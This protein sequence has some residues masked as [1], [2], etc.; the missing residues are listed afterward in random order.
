M[1]DMPHT[2]SSPWYTRLFWAKS[3]P[4]RQRGPDRIHL[5]E[6]H[7]ADVGACLEA[8]LAQP[9][10]RQRLANTAGREE[11]D[12][13]TVGRLCVFAAIHDI[14][15]V[16]I[17]FQAQV[18][19]PG[20]M[21]GNR[22]IRRTGHTVDMVPVLTGDDER[23]YRWFSDALG[24]PDL[25]GWDDEGGDVVRDLL[26]ATL[27]HHGL[28]LNLYSGPARNPQVWRPVG[29]LDPESYVRR[30]GE[31][32]RVW[33]AAA[34]DT[35]APPLPAEPSFQHMFL[36]L[37]TLADW[38][39]SNEHWFPY[40][41][42]P[43][44][45]YINGARDR[46]QSAVAECG[47][48]IE[49]QRRAV[50]DR[51][52]L[53]GFTEL[54]G[55]PSPNAIQRQAAQQTPLDER[56]VVVES[57]TGS[58]KTEAALWRF[59]RLYEANRVDGL[60]FAL[61]TRAAATQMHDRIRRFASAVFPPGQVP[62][63]VLAVPGYPRSDHAS[64]KILQRYEVWWDDH[65]DDATRRRRW[66]AEHSKRYL[67]AQIAVGTV[68]QAMMAALKVK[69]SHMRAACL[70]RNLLVIDE[71]H[72]SD[73]YMGVILQALLDAHLGAG[74]HALLMSATLGSVARRRWLGSGTSI[75]VDSLPLEEAIR[76]PYPAVSTR[77]GKGERMVAT[78]GNG[79]EKTVRIRSVPL[80]SRFDAV[81]ERVLDAARA[82][83]KVLVIRNTVGHAIHTQRA[84]EGAVATP[85]RRLLF[86]LDG[87]H[88]PHHGRFAAC[89]RSGLDR[90]VEE[91]L[92]KNANRSG[93]GLVVVGT[94]TLEQSLDIDADLLVTDLCPVD[95]LLQRIGRLHRHAGKDRPPGYRT[96][97]CFVMLPGSGDLT[98][99]L[100][101]GVNGLNH[102][103]YQDLRILEATRRLVADDPEWVIPSINRWLVEQAT[104]PDALEAITEELGGGWLGHTYRVTGGELAEGLT[105]RGAIA[106]RD[107]SFCRD[108]HEVTFGSMEDKIRTRLGDEGIEV[109]LDPPQ[110]SPFSVGEIERM[111]VPRR[112]LPE[113][114][115]DQPAVPEPDADGFTFSVGGRQFRYNRL[116]LQR[117]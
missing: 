78:G 99:L 91:R 18:W 39:G 5:L 100:E 40:R 48:D 80:M 94:Q 12:D 25:V 42:E 71:V 38:L 69:H 11:L 20:D 83:A 76:S 34:W 32:V 104:H 102:F 8:L 111:V 4:Y 106:A 54:F 21:G 115:E 90:L 97:T 22:R 16:N 59:A 95:V 75:G 116:G 66:A 53:P 37:C 74:G 29:D 24:W 41:S 13:A 28:P 92:G 14:G 67:A 10:I 93:G 52:E 77:A 88:A 101:R 65:P 43:D 35:T 44:A 79:E 64:G 49:D 56:L 63:V 6:H 30:I 17:G 36:G 87:V 57:E 81:A 84:I 114:W 19:K 105:A 15:K 60:Y 103:V 73:T 27:S 89:D 62:P 110:P 9:T 98:P 85:E 31:L 45:A 107:K 26:I 47:L 50:H 33:F 55:Y 61:P 86:G 72:A 70:A 82:G 51:G 7:L 117:D 2:A 112:W 68:D 23:A 58:G 3:W 96:P 1:I 109:D 113:R 108:N 46:A